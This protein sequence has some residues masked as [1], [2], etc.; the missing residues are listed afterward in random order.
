VSRRVVVI[1]LG[2]AMRGDDAAGLHAARR[3]AHEPGVD[4]R[5]HEGE[6]VDLLDLW[7]DADVAILVDAVRSGAPPGTI[8]HADASTRA[9][10]VTFDRPSGHAI[11]AAATIELARALDQLPA[12]VLVYG[13]EGRDFTLGA[14]LS[15]PVADA[16]DPLVQAVRSEIGA[17]SGLARSD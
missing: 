4:V 14:A 6:G 10:A 15:P 7:A 17:R 2:N 9:L 3:L 11:G 12:T 8:H 16:I 5:V 1:G 13:V